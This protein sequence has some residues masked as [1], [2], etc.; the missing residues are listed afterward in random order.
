MK[1]LYK[2]L[3]SWI[4]AARNPGELEGP[5]G[6]RIR[7]FCG[8]SRRL[9]YLRGLSFPEFLANKILLREM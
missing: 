6:S 8:D 2:Y 7:R 3:L 9:F 5:Q 1:C 4:F